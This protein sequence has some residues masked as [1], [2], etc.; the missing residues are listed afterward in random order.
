MVTVIGDV[1][2]ENIGREACMGTHGI[3]QMNENGE[4][5]LDFCEMNGLV[6]C[7]T[8]FAHK[9][10]HKYIIL[11]FLQIRKQKIRSVTS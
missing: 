9:N 6:V 2:N 11:G 1:G 8:I 7:N 4:R 5:L 3:G 10:I